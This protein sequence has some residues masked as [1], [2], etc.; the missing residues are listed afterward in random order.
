MRVCAFFAGTLQSSPWG[1]FLMLFAVLL[2]LCNVLKFWAC[3]RSEE[4]LGREG[5]MRSE[6]AAL[7]RF[8][9][10]YLLAE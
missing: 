9:P 2:I 8:G 7:C 5:N 10:A 1:N 4:E 6:P 3:S